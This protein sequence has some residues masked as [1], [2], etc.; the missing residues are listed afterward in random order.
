MQIS[1][2]LSK[3]VV[4]Y[5]EGNGSKKEQV[6]E[7][8]DNIAPSYDLLNHALSFGVDIL[9]RKNAIKHLKPYQPKVIVDMATGTGDF[10]IEALSL[11]PDK[12]IG[13]DISPEMLEVGK[14]KMKKK[15]VDDRIEM[16]IGD[17]EDIQLDDK[18]VDAF[19]V[20]FGVR[21][22]ENL[23]KGLGEL[24]RIL[25]PG[26]AGAILEPSF[27]TSFPLKQLFQLHFRVLTPILG[28]M[29]SGDDA[30]YKY[31]PES[32]RAFPNGKEFTD[33]CQ[34]VGFSKATYY[35]LAFGMCSMYILE[36]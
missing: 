6:V 13:I 27:P 32:V 2:K 33:I 3:N 20:G 1:K 34:G 12:V 17:S 8:F 9:W 16:I 21:N 7:M 29:I 35:P 15:G 14:Q 19:T 30:A 10:A 4:P 25:K 31:L 5:A 28:K 11:N 22:F 24:H 36:K 23:N 26:G 18:S